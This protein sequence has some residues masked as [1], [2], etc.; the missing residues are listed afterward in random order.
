ML[1]ELKLGPQ[2]WS[3]V[4]P[5]I[6][7][8]LNE[9]SI[10]R[11]GRLPDGPARSPLEVMTG[12]LPKRP[13]LRVLPAEAN[14]AS[15]KTIA[16]ARALQLIRS[17]ELQKTLDE[18]HKD[19]QH[20]VSLRRERAIA[21][22]NKATNII[23]PSFTVGDFVLVRRAVDRGHKLQFR[24]FGPCCVTSVHGDLVYGVTS[25]RGG[26]TERVH[27]A[28]LLRY[29]DSLL[30]KPIPQDMLE[31]AERTE[32]RY[33]V[34]EKIVDLGQDRDVLF[35]RVQWEGLPDEQ[36]YTW[37]PVEEL[38]DDVPDVVN[39]FLSSFKKK[40]KVVAAVKRNLGISF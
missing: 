28:R 17:E 36:D 2:D 33:E 24:W 27:C 10:D 22:H 37:Q 15:A 13:L 32:S 38:Y 5:A 1:A 8:A 7:S 34:I 6:A 12:M 9:A 4:I 20:A 40:K 30:G 18:I 39:A 23:S 14:H 26:K 35:F 3:S 16:R 25:L 21:V 19:V 29:R 31:L 11:L